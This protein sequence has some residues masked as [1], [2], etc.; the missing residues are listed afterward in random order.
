MKPTAVRHSGSRR[1]DQCPI[2]NFITKPI[3]INLSQRAAKIIPPPVFWSVFY[4]GWRWFYQG[5]RSG[6]SEWL[7]HLLNGLNA[8]SYPH[9]WFPWLIAGLYLATPLIHPFAIRASRGT[10]LY[11]GML[12]FVVTAVLPLLSRVNGSLK[13]GLYTQPVARY[14]GYFVLGA[15][16]VRFMSARPSGRRLASW[17]LGTRRSARA[18]RGAVDRNGGCL[19]FRM[20]RLRSSASS[21]FPWRIIRFEMAR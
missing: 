15:S 5:Q 16:L 3:T 12:W 18:A 4:D 17:T 9:L 21:K 6:P 11:F 1:G 10:H 2:A 20:G 13:I 7:A 8:P 19:V 14:V